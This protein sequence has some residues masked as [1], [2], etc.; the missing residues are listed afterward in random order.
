MVA[1]LAHARRFR[2]SR[3]W[4]G[5]TLVCEHARPRSAGF[6]L[7]ARLPSDAAAAVDRAGLLRY[8]IAVVLAGIA[9]PR[10]DN[11]DYWNARTGGG[12]T[13]R[14]GDCRLRNGTMAHLQQMKQPPTLLGCANSRQS[15]EL[16]KKIFYRKHLIVPSFR[17]IERGC[18]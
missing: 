7:D 8:R 10:G 3:D 2:I 17:G 12:N 1:A 6:E 15:G 9:G 13:Q 5:D 16:A 14:V 11:M 4:A 18:Q